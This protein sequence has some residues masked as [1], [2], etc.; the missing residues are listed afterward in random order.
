LFKKN[1]S[2]NIDYEIGVKCY[3]Y[4]LSRTLDEIRPL[5]EFDVSCQC[6]VPH[7]ITVFLESTSFEDAVRNAV[8]I[9]G[10]SDTIA[11]ITG[12]IAEAA[13]GIPNWI[14]EKAIGYLNSPLIEVYTR[15]A[16]QS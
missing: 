14:K 16:S 6:S 11:T 12:S 5:Y 10:D 3:G 13:Y 8:S 2:K 7:A 1:Y 4:N 9:G 15:W